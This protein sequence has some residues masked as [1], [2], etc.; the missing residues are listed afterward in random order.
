MADPPNTRDDTDTTG[1]GHIQRNSTLQWPTLKQPPWH[2]VEHLLHTTIAAD[3]SMNPQASTH[4]KEVHERRQVLDEFA[5]LIIALL[6]QTLCND[7]VRINQ[8]LKPNFTILY[9]T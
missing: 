7:I 9:T 4:I 6:V 8:K 1:E 2:L 3:L 5:R